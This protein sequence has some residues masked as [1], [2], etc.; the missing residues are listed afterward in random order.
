MLLPN[1]IN[2]GIRGL[3]LGSRFFFII[4]ISKYLDAAS[5]GY[6]GLFTASV[7]YALYF[8][9]LDFYTYV[10]REIVKTPT[11]K[12]G[13]LLK[14]QAA[15]SGLIYLSL[16][17]VAM[18]FLWK[19]EWPDHLV[20]WFIPILFF[21]HVNQE[22]SRLL[23]VLSEPL[24][25]SLIQFIRQGSWVLASGALMNFNNHARNL[26]L[27][28]SFWLIAGLIAASTGVWKLHHLK[29][30][31]WNLPIDWGWVKKGVK[32][33][34]TLLLATLALRGI[35]TFDRYWIE[36]LNGIEL[37]GAYVLFL[38]LASTLLTFLDAGV[39]AFAYPVLI[40]LNDERSYIEFRRY[41]KNLLFQTVLISIFFVCATLSLLPYLLAW[42]GKPLYLQLEWMYAGLLVSI[43]IYSVSMVPHI[44]LY[45]G[46]FDK[47][48]IYSHINA[49]LVFVLATWQISGHYADFSV[50]I[51]LCLSFL[52]ILIWNSIAYVQMIKK[53][54]N[55]NS[56]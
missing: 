35:N 10:S 29:T 1:L 7:G 51:G 33:S 27:I 8:V 2:V 31:G 42:I 32:V 28:I 34:I 46:G 41:V 40:K 12:R 50:L 49:L 9:G 39:F 53:I 18:F 4:V 21:E 54:V 36:A 30:Q 26:D 45:A 56:I 52:S 6:Y 22:I 48:I 13:Q 43:V 25:S 16:F 23:I 55:Y 3:T 44:A 38:G 19:S 14:G 5:V 17:P 20:F 37:V 11:E 47:A 24:T 15:L